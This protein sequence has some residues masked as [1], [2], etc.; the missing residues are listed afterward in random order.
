MNP[1]ERV[2]T[3]VRAG[4]Q[5]GCELNDRVSIEFSPNELLTLMYHFRGQAMEAEEY[6]LQ[7]DMREKQK[8]FREA[9]HQWEDTRRGIK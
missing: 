8:T 9:H 6:T 7:T 4:V 5:T 3:V 1:E 2:I